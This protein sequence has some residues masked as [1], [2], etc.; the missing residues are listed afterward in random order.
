VNVKTRL[1]VSITVVLTLALAGPVAVIATLTANQARDDGLRYAGSL[2][3]SEAQELETGITRQMAAAQNLG[4]TLSVLAATRQGDRALADAVEEQT[5][6]TNEMSRSVTEA[7]QGTGSL[8]GS[9]TTISAV[10]SETGA[11]AAQTQSAAEGLAEVTIELS[12][13]VAQFKV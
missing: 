6:T 5:A 13:L 2:A 12:R 1:V 4:T 10:S 8:A 9:I 11:D 7:A 3:V